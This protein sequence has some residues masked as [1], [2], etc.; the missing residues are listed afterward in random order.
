M[1]DMPGIQSAALEAADARD[2]L[3]GR[4]QIAE[5]RIEELEQEMRRAHAAAQQAAQQADQ[6]AASIAEQV[7]QTPRS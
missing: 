3:A 7:A 5:A 4:C 1:L 6:R 2:Q